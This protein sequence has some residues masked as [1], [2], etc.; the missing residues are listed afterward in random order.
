MYQHN[1]EEEYMKKWRTEKND[2]EMREQTG[3]VTVWV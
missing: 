2:C 1:Y 3:L